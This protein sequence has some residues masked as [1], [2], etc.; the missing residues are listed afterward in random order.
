MLLIGIELTDLP[1]RIVFSYNSSIFLKIW[2]LIPKNLRDK[3]IGLSR[4]IRLAE[5]AL[6]DNNI[7]CQT[8]YRNLDL[9][10]KHLTWIKF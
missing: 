9:L 2:A 5:A 7:Y 1:A 10:I 8:D 3:K 6:I 4:T